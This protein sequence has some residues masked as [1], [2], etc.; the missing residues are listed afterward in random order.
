[1]GIKKVWEPLENKRIQAAKSEFEAAGRR[2]EAAWDTL[3][4]DSADDPDSGK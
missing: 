4:D 1:M 3:P 2:K